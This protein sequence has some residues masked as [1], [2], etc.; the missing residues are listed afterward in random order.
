MVVRV[1]EWLSAVVQQSNVVPWS[2]NVPHV[3]VNQLY[4]LN[5]SSPS[6]TVRKCKDA[7]ESVKNVL[8]SQHN[9]PYSIL[10][11]QALHTLPCLMRPATCLMRSLYNA[12]TFV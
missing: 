8:Y 1:M 3:V 11:T 2:T 7:N 9:Q 12:N 4:K 5:E 10:N 6:T